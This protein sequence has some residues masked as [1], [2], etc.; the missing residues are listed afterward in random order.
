MIA[1]LRMP[2]RV[3]RRVLIDSSDLL[4]DHK[5]KEIAL[6]QTLKSL[7]VTLKCATIVVMHLALK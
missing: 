7:N 2:T 3:Y 5:T 4:S 6:L 1:L